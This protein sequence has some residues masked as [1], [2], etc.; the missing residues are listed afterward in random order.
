M[1]LGFL[2]IDDVFLSVPDRSIP[3]PT[4]V[5]SFYTFCCSSQ[6]VLTPVHCEFYV[7]YDYSNA[8]DDDDDDDGLVFYSINSSKIHRLG[9][10]SMKQKDRQTDRP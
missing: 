6:C 2:E 3:L 4:H 5:V 10:R 7:L 8:H 1:L 9:D